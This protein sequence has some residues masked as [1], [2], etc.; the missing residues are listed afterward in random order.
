M[1]Y[2]RAPL[3]E[4]LGILSPETASALHDSLEHYVGNGGDEGDLRAALRQVTA[5]ARARSVPPEQLMI[6][7]KALW[8][9]L[10]AVRATSDPRLRARLLE[11]LITA[12]I[13]EYFTR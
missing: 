6:A 1:A 10:P 2:D 4:P 7:F 13:Q 3:P 12:S 9:Q 8:E 11:R 5:E